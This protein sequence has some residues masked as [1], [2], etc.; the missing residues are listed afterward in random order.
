MSKG[1]PPGKKKKSTP[2]VRKLTVVPRIVQLNNYLSPVVT[3]F[4]GSK[5]AVRSFLVLVTKKA[6]VASAALD[7]YH[8]PIE[9]SNLMQ[10]D[11]D[12]RNLVNT[13]L[14]QANEVV[15]S[16]LYERLVH[17]E[18]EEIYAGGKK[19]G[20]KKKFVTKGIIDYLRAS[21]ASSEKAAKRR[22]TEDM[23]DAVEFQI[24]VFEEDK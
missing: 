13:S 7:L 2:S 10:L 24:P 20:E 8:N 3:D 19:V 5:K 9:V 22:V 21:E 15:K 1:R 17:G 4:F 16:A 11:A 6:S 23:G 18:I 12:F 14:A